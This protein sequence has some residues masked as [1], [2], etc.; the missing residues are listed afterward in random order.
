MTFSDHDLFNKG[1]AKGLKE[2]LSCPSREIKEAYTKAA[3]VVEES[4]K[5]SRPLGPEAEIHRLFPIPSGT[6][7]LV[8]VLAGERQIKGEPRP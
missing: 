6:R 2:G 5:N 4:R 1:Y 3:K 8:E 7:H